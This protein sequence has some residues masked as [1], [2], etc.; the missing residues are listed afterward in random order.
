MDIENAGNYTLR[1]LS[2]INFLVG[3]NGC[4]KS[5]LLKEVE[6]ATNGYQGYG[7]TK[8]ITPERGGHLQY[9]AGVEHNMASNAEWMTSTRRV[10]QFN[11]FKQQSVA[12]YRKLETLVLRELEKSLAL[13]NDPDYTFDKYV[14]EINSLLDNIEIRR[15]ES[16][17]QI[18]RKGTNDEINPINISSGEA[19]L[20]SLGIECLVFEKEC[21][22]GQEN[23]LYLDSP[24]VHLHPDLQ[25]RL[26]GFLRKLVD[27]TPFR[28]VLATHSTATLGSLLNYEHQAITFMLPGHMQLEFK[29]ISVIYRK[30]LPMFG[31]HP[32]SNFFNEAPV[33][34]VDGED[35]ERVWQQAVRT[36]QGQLKIYPCPVDGEAQMTAYEQEIQQIINSVYDDAV[37]FSL[38]DRDNGPEEINDLPPIT[39]MRL[40]CRAAENLLLSDDVLRSLGTDWDTLV[41]GI[42]S[43]IDD[44]PEH[45]HI[46]QMAAFSESLDRKLWD[47]KAIRNDLMGIIGSNKPWEVAI[48]QVIGG[49]A[50]GGNQPVVDHSIRDYLGTKLLNS[51]LN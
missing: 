27:R 36:A 31:A 17:F 15:H 26:M 18:V 19:E 32:L 37:A 28:V 30:I 35:D 25:V 49:L 41:A 2:K 29:P 3:K 24:D 33:L 42:R 34:L 40:S 16:T 1:N 23:F 20:I 14:N 51:I 45:P 39:R 7:T 5:I 50:R 21:V 10:N 47:V 8:Y 9:E 38:R 11:Q 48:G 46:Q 44:N 43:W 22:Q 12:Q 13:R 6:T 4:S